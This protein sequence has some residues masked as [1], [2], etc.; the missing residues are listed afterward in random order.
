MSSVDFAFFPQALGGHLESTITTIR[1]G[2]SSKPNRG[3]IV[4]AT[5]INNHAAKGLQKLGRDE[6]AIAQGRDSVKL[7]G[8]F[9]EA[10][11]LLDELTGTPGNE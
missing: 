5:W 10:S 11:S 8:D 3:K 7:N 6:E 4:S 1:A 2:A 9:A